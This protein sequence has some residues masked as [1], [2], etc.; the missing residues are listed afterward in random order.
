M[1]SL[2]ERLKGIIRDVPDFPKKG[3]TFKDI[4][5]ILSNAEVMRDIT[6]FLSVI[7]QNQEIDAIIGIESRGFIFGPI[8]AQALGVPFVPVRKSGKLP[9]NKVSQSYDLE[10]GEDQLEIHTDAIKEG[11]KV[12]IHDDLLAT[13][14][15]AEAAS[16][17][18]N[19]LGGVIAGYTFLIELQF[20]NGRDYI[21]KYTDGNIYSIVKY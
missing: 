21:Q 10:Y 19:K 14:G 3:I 2:E 17:L 11:D 4:T 1:N 20:L 16:K 13:G 8:M 6:N 5:P 12:L 9:Y 18:V 7:Y 15:T